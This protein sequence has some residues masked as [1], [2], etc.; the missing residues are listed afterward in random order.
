LT[1]TI[2]PL[3][4]RTEEIPF[5]FSSL[6]EQG[7][8]QAA[9]PRLDPL[10]V[11]RLCIYGWPLNVRELVQ[12]VNAILALYPDAAVLDLGLLEKLNRV[13]DGMVQAPGAPPTENDDERRIP[14]LATDKV[15]AALRANGGNVKRTAAAL[16][17]SRSRIYRL[18]EK[19]GALDLTA[20]RKGEDT[21]SRHDD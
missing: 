20:L 5:L 9:A 1:V 6:L 10:L 8:G 14:E 17:T 11:E 7:R 15:L 13:N 19:L 2:P 16:K 3:R 18:I 21:P 12:L 4:Q